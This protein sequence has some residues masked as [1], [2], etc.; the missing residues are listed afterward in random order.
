MKIFVAGIAT[1]T[2]TFSPIPTGLANFSIARSLDDWAQVSGGGV[3]NIA[4]EC[5]QT[6][7][8]VIHSV[9]AFAEP[10][11]ITVRPAY[12]TLREE[13][14]ADL[15]QHKDADIVILLLHGAMVA[16]GYDDCEVDLTSR[17]RAIVGDKAVIGLELDLHA[18]ID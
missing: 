11:G 7:D 18:H 15:E 5:G 10:A 2:N 13:I 12:E 17:C 1:E 6:G 16:D 9:V 3:K 14:L 8:Q 4:E